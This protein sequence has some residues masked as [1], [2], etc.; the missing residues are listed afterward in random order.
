MI[1]NFAINSVL[2]YRDRRLKRWPWLQGLSGV[3]MACRV[4]AVA[5]VGLTT[6]LFGNRIQWMLAAL[7]GALVGAYGI[8]R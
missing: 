5:N 2:T 1:F 8:M 6:Y 4:G 3:M 7:A